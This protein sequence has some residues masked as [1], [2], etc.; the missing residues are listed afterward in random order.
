MNKKIA[1]GGFLSIFGAIMAGLIFLS[2]A[3][4]TNL[5]SSYSGRGSSIFSKLDFLGDPLSYF[6]LFLLFISILVIIVGLCLLFI[7]WAKAIKEEKTNR[8]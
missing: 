7:E 5:D 1:I 8:K 4:Q 3:I 2:S 6:I